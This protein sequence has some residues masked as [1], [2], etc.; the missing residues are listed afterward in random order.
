MRSS[1]PAAVGLLAVLLGGCSTAAQS[2]RQ[3]SPGEAAATLGAAKITVEEVDERALRQSA[4]KFGGLK[5]SQALY[6]ARRQALDEIVGTRLIDQEAKSLGMDRS[7]LVEREITAKAPTPSEQDI[8]TWYKANPGRVQGA[9]LDQVKE[10]IRSLLTEERTQAARQQYLDAL[11]A[12][13]SVKILLEPPRE[14]VPAAGRP[15]RGRPDAPVEIIEFS[16]FQ[17]P[18]CLRAHPVVT[19]VL[20]QYGDRVRLV[21]RHYPLPNHPQARPAAEAASC[22]A[23][24]GKFW[25]YHDRLFTDQ[26]ALT[27]RDFKRHAVELGLDQARFSGCLESHK[28][29]KD[30][31]ADIAAGNEVGVSGTPA[32]FINGR[33]LDGA[34]P[35]EVFKRVLDEELARQR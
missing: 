6:E 14:K 19:E 24:Q 22:A 21:Y 27:D 15:S 17:C 1:F 3:S 4:A 9:T 7:A 12:K 16:D 8:A 25:P 18:F 20:K 29:A 2:S 23:E 13:T 32:F 28:Y 5:L 35:F 34:Q 26:N 31:D 30:I 11:K 10:P 33:E